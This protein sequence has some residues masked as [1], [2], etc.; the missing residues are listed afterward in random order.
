M[1][2]LVFDTQEGMQ[3][4]QFAVLQ[5]AVRSLDWFDTDLSETRAHEQAYADAIRTMLTASRIAHARLLLIS[6][7]H[8]W[9]HC[10]QLNGLLRI[11]GHVFEV[12]LL[13]EGDRNGAERFLLSDTAVARRFHA[14]AYRGEASEDGQ[15]R[16]LCRQRF[17]SMW[18]RAHLPR[19]G[20]QLSI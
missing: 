12:R 2:T 4:A 17:E 9:R 5:T 15:A 18:A 3:A 14:D 8:F 20:R 10:T 6:D 1:D 13:D 19:E 11:Y 7:T 16:A